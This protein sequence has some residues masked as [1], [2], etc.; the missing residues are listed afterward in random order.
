MTINRL[1]WE[2]C[3][4]TQGLKRHNVPAELHVY[5]NGGH[6]YGM[7]PRKNSNIGTWPDRATDWLLRRGLARANDPSP[8][9][10]E[11]NVDGTGPL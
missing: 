2:A 6:G 1:R 7:R 11:V 10:S 9:K 8:A 4:F 5:E 3:S